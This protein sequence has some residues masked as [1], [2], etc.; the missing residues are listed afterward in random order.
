[1]KFISWNVNGIRACAGKG[2]EDE[3]IADEKDSNDSFTSSYP[4]ADEEYEENTDGLFEMLEKM[5]KLI[6]DAM[7]A[8][9]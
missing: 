8:K 6:M 3:H 9:K 1:M 5:I 4:M 2:F 7:V